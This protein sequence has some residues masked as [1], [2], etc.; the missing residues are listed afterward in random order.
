[1]ESAPPFDGHKGE[2]LTFR[3]WDHQL[4][5]PLYVAGPRKREDIGGQLGPFAVL[6]DVGGKNLDALGTAMADSRCRFAP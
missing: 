4:R 2:A 1:M 5:Q 3:K 6:A